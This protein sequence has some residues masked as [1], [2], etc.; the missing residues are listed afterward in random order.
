MVYPYLALERVLVSCQLP[1]FRIPR[2][3]VVP[4]TLCFC[5]DALEAHALLLAGFMQP[6]VVRELQLLSRLEKAVVV[7][8]EVR[9]RENK[10]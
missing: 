5:R 8:M 10:E 1:N 9:M 3:A 6:N 2:G 4:Q 7:D